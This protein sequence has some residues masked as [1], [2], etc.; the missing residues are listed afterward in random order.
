MARTGSLERQIAVL[1]HESLTRPDAAAGLISL[2][3]DLLLSGHPI[4]PPLA[5][6][7]ADALLK[8]ATAPG[9]KRGSVLAQELR[10]KQSANAPIKG[11]R[12]DAVLLVA[13]HDAKVQSMP[14]PPMEKELVTQI[15]DAIS[16]SERTALK[17]ISEIRATLRSAPSLSTK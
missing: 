10:L 9:P 15:M 2:A 1:L 16:V 3:S 14:N 5:H 11:R 8:A 6:F 4:P 17:R 7:L 12:L 13:A